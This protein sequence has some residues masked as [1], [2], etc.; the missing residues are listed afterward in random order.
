MKVNA[1][2]LFEVVRKVVR[3]ELRQ[4]LPELIREHLAEHYVRRVLAEQVHASPVSLSNEVF[5]IVEPPPPPRRPVPLAERTTN[6]AP[7]SLPGVPSFLLEGVKPLSVDEASNPT[8]LP[9]FGGFDMGAIAN[10][11]DRL[12]RKLQA[13][14][15][16][17]SSASNSAL[18]EPVH[19]RS[20]N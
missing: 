2:A 11:S 16:T 5:D 6:A 4:A 1:K 7:S 15:S 9:D 19:V 14:R 8:V 10:I 17:T 3:D 18:D 13:K 12:E 20:S